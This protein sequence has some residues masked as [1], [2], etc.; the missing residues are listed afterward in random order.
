MYQNYP[1]ALSPH[2]HQLYLQIQMDD[3]PIVH[4]D[5]T[6]DEL[7]QETH[8]FTLRKTVPLNDAFK[9]LTS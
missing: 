4:V 7:F 6:I 1:L 3:A 2:S 9:Q 8:S 5:E